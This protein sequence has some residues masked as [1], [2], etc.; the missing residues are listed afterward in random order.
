MKTCCF[1][2]LQW[3]AF[4]YYAF[5]RVAECEQAIERAA[6]IAERLGSPRFT[7]EMDYFR[8][9]RLIWTVAIVTVVRCWFVAPGERCVAC[10]P[11]SKWPRATRAGRGRMDLRR[12][13]GA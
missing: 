7:W 10:A 8:G 3:S 1:A 11:T 9:Q 6:E 2:S 4:V 12:R 13:D 5:G